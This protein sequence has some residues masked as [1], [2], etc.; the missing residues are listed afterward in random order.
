MSEN[1]LSAIAQ[2]KDCDRQNSSNL[3]ENAI[4][5]IS[6]LIE[7]GNIASHCK[8]KPSD[9][10]TEK[11]DDLHRTLEKIVTPPCKIS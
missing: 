1:D 11:R 7:D 2:S 3:T 6:S 8:I 4:A 5:Q 10:S 9:W